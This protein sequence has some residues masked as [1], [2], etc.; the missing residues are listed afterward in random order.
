LIYAKRPPVPNVP[1]KNPVQEAVSTLKSNQSLKTTI[2][3]DAELCIPIWHAGMREAFLMH[4]STTLDAIKKEGTFRAYTEA[5]ELYVEHCEAAKQA[6]AAW[7]VLNAA[8]SE[9]EKTSKRLPRR[10]REAR[11]WLTH[12]TLNCTQN[13]RRTLRR[14][15][16][17]QRLPRT[18]ENQMVQFYVNLLSSDSKYVWNK[19]V[20][21]QTKTDPYDL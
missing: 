15:N 20:K 2:E 9:G 1:E 18:R 16:L 11:L 19:I 14:P 3:D 4:V 10:Q 13:T 12:Q 7:A 5:C 8:T 21:E 6:K 17:L